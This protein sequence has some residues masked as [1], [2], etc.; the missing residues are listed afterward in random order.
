VNTTDI[1]L[2]HIAL[3][4]TYVS[5]EG[6]SAMDMETPGPSRSK[7]MEALGAQTR[8]LVILS[9]VKPKNA[10]VNRHRIRHL[11][12]HK[13]DVAWETLQKQVGASTTI[14]PSWCEGEGCQLPSHGSYVFEKKITYMVLRVPET[15]RRRPFIVRDENDLHGN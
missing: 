7:W 6:R 3:K 12:Y 4:P 8:F 1:V 14:S 11:W 10:S 9:M 2:F 15:E 5:A 13:A